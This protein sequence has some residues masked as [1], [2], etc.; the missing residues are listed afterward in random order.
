MAQLLCEFDN[1]FKESCLSSQKAW[2]S[3]DILKDQGSNIFLR[4]LSLFSLENC[5]SDDDGGG[6]SKHLYNVTCIVPSIFST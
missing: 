1:R 5:K 4:F 2:L 6:D 3:T